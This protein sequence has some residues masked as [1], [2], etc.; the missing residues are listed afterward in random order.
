MLIPTEVAAELFV[1]DSP[2][3]VRE[4]GLEP[5]SSHV[6]VSFPC[7]PASHARYLSL[8]LSL[9]VYVRGCLFVLLFGFLP[10]PLRKLRFC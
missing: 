5:K 9:S 7:L 1:Q 10:V 6:G 8:S 3:L 4:A 2:A